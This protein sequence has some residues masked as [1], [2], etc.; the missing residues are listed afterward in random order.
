MDKPPSGPA[1]VPLV[2]KVG[3]RAGHRV[4]LWD[5][6][7]GFAIEDLPDGVTV[8][9]AAGAADIVLAFFACAGDLAAEIGALARTIM[10]DGS[11]WV[12]WPRRAAGHTSDITD[13]VVRE[14][15]LPLGLVDVKVA[16]LGHDW[17]GLKFVWRKQRRRPGPPATE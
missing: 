10:P 8:T 5:A 6:P 4:L 3:I 14:I 17:S 16:A 15:V 1:D 9:T 2:R 13:H 7:T 11:I 12:A